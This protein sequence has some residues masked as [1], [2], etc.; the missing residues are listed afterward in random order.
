[1]GQP[2]QGEL[3]DLGAPLQRLATAPPNVSSLP[4]ASTL[5]FGPDFCS[6][7]VANIGPLR[8]LVWMEDYHQTQRLRA[9]ILEPDPVVNSGYLEESRAASQLIGLTAQRHS[10]PGPVRSVLTAHP[11]PHC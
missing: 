2:R 8:S 9:R 5:G 6:R 11:G 10:L 4:N 7:Q 3:Q 1:M